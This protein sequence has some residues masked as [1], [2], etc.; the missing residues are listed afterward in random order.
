[1]C[2]ISSHGDA[3]SSAPGAMHLDSEAIPHL[4]CPS[5]THT[6][7]LTRFQGLETLASLTVAAGHLHALTVLRGPPPAVQH[8]EDISEIKF[9]L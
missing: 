7:P 3:V 4:E 8:E 9:V 2:I 1:L 6:G 5:S